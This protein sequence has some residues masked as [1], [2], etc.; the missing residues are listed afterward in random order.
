MMAILD[1]YCDFYVEVDNVQN[2]A[3]RLF[4]ELELGA[5]L[6]LQSQEDHVKVVG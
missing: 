2:K 4:M 6:T 1:G 3:F 5:D